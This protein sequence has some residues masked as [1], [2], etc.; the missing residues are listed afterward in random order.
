M[1]VTVVEAPSTTS[2]TVNQGVVNVNTSPTTVAVSIAEA[3]GPAGP[4]GSIGPQGPPGSSVAF[5]NV[6]IQSSQPVFA[7][8][9][10]W[11]QPIGNNYSVW[12][13]P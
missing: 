5:Q 11:I 8:P 1:D 9:F 10:L 3:Q 7:Q 13:G 4:Q 6:F 12:V 2:V